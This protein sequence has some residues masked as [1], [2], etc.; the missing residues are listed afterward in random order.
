MSTFNIEDFE[1]LPPEMAKNHELVDGELIDLA[2]RRDF[3]SEEVG[4][5]WE[6]RYGDF[7]AGI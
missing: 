6:H 3:N 2:R 1:R 4:G 5:G 7:G